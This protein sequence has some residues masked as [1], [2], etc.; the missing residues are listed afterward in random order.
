MFMFLYLLLLLFTHPCLL[1]SAFL[2]YLNKKSLFFFGISRT[3]IF[4]QLHKLYALIALCE[5]SLFWEHSRKKVWFEVHTKNWLVPLFYHKWYFRFKDIIDT[6]LFACLLEKTDVHCYWI[7][8]TDRG[9][10]F[11]TGCNGLFF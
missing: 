7:W 3:N 6:V 4:N 10:S 5:I 1:D 11:T 2:V 9:S 8:N